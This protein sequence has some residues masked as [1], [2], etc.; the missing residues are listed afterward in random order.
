MLESGSILS[1]VFQRGAPSKCDGRW[2][3]DE[4]VG[5]FI[6][7]PVARLLDIN[8]RQRMRKSLCQLCG[9]SLRV[10]YVIGIQ[11][12]TFKIVLIEARFHAVESTAR[13][14]MS[15]LQAFRGAGPI[16]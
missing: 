4:I 11:N 13:R 14:G 5:A 16:A 12:A 6:P 9:K 3:E 10:N 15:T 8:I 2:D 7:E 1:Q